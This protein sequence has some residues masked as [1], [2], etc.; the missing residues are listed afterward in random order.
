MVRSLEPSLWAIDVD[1][2]YSSVHL[3][4]SGLTPLASSGL[5][6]G[7]FRGY[8][9]RWAGPGRVEIST[10]ASEISAS[11]LDS[12]DVAGLLEVGRRGH[13]PSGWVLGA[14]RVSFR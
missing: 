4:S 10:V 11:W 3:I 9:C 14:S 8:R 2:H 12:M 7:R 1:R 13:R 5:P 6:R